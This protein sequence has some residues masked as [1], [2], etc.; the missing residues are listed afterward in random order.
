M[1]IT[2]FAAP[3]AHTD[4]FVRFRLL[5]C[6]C[7]FVCARAC[8]LESSCCT[9]G[10]ASRRRCESSDTSGPSGCQIC[11]SEKLQDLLAR[12]RTH[13]R[14]HTHT[15]TH[16]SNPN[17]THDHTLLRARSPPEKWAAPSLNASVV[18]GVNESA[19]IT[20]QLQQRHA[21]YWEE[22]RDKRQSA[23]VRAS[24]ACA[25]LTYLVRMWSVTGGLAFRTCAK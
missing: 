20:R 23:T 18:A 6:V 14:T 7:V 15:H 21:L 5:V 8:R 4:A 11:S 17:L 2:Q 9:R 12:A 24:L 25:S 13:T 19:E 22:L 1:M 10:T 3:F 16:I